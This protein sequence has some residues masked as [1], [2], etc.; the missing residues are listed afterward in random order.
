MNCGI[1]SDRIDSGA[2]G[3]NAHAALLRACGGDKVVGASRV[4]AA[5]HLG[6]RRGL[7]PGGVPT[8]VFG[9]AHTT[10]VSVESAFWMPGLLQ[11]QDGG[12][13]DGGKARA[14]VPV[15]GDAEVMILKG[16]PPLMHAS[17]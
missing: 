7:A 13:V 10:V 9:G 16:A 6:H 3:G 8:A 4:G 12:V 11:R 15:V 14:G 2:L 5:C 17:G 1:V